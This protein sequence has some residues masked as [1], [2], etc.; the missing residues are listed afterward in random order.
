MLS[1]CIPTYRYDVCP[2]VADLLQQAVTVNE[3]IEVLV[4]DD[5]S[6]DDG[7]WGRAELRQTSGIRYIAIK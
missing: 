4:Y 2:L 3:A 7:D 5:A 1:I 6:P